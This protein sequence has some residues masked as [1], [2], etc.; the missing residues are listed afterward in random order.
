[1]LFQRPQFNF[2][3]PHASS[4]PSAIPVPGIQCP[5]LSSEGIRH[6]HGTQ[7]DMQGKTPMHIKISEIIR[8][9]GAQKTI[10]GSGGLRSSLRFKLSL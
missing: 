6:M 1:M 5:L 2:L 8:D 4:Q 7:I 10:P 9:V 3:H